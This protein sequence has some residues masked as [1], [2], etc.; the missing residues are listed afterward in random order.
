[1]VVTPVRTLSPF[2]MVTWPTN[3]PATSVMAF[4]SPVGST[5]GLM[6][7]SRARG[8]DDASGCALSVAAQQLKTMAMTILN[9]FYSVGAGVSRGIGRARFSETKSS[10][11]RVRSR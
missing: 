6:P 10:K 5:P 2:Q 11:R 4:H 8:R 3:T 1:M 7:M 9:L